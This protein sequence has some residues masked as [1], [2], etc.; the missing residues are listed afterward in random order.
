MRLGDQQQD[1]LLQGW[2]QPF[3]LG[4]RVQHHAQRIVGGSRHRSLRGHRPP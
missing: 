1:V 3:Q 2:Q 4:E